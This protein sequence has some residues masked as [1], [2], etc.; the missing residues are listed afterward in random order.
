MQ[1][2]EPAS[3]HHRPVVV[4]SCMSVPSSAKGAAAQ[5]GGISSL[6]FGSWGDGDTKGRLCC[7]GF[8]L[9]SLSSTK[10]ETAVQPRPASKKLLRWSKIIS[11]PGPQTGLAAFCWAVHCNGK[12]HF[13]QPWGCSPT[14]SGGSSSAA[15]T[16]LGQLL[17]AEGPASS[18]P[19][20]LA[21]QR[22][23][24]ELEGQ[25]L[26]WAVE[27]P[28]G[29][30]GDQ[31]A[32]GRGLLQA[33]ALTAR[34]L[35]AFPALLEASLFW[36]QVREGSDSPWKGSSCKVQGGIWGGR[37]LELNPP[38]HFCLAPHSSTVLRTSQTECKLSPSFSSRPSLQVSPCSTPLCCSWPDSFLGLPALSSVL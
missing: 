15:P 35:L 26:S 28:W 33:G 31:V 16:G 22:K 24:P 8:G 19:L 34:W 14:F 17:P 4:G 36:G 38:S 2:T 12:V 13:A 1:R 6:N 3:T 9:V 32:V 23:E 37:V 25:P 11:A 21:P 30:G 20:N 7:S 29:A 10:L 27:V 5:W 18:A